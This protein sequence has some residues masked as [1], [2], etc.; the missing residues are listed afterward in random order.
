VWRT[1]PSG[2]DRDAGKISEGFGE[3]RRKCMGQVGL[4]EA[5]KEK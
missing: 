1:G 5:T 2:S 4:W 3:G